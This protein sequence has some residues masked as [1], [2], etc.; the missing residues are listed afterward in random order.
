MARGRARRTTTNKLFIMNRF[1][2]T[3]TDRFDGKQMLFSDDV[4]GADFVSAIK[5]KTHDIQKF[6]MFGDADIDIE[7]GMTG[8]VVA[9]GTVGCNIFSGVVEVRLPVAS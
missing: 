6:V 7:D 2:F 4:K 1:T 9:S 5:K 3:L 8:E